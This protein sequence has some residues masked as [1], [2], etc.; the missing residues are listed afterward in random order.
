M[1]STGIVKTFGMVAVEA[2]V[3][4]AGLYLL[5][6]RLRGQATKTNENSTESKQTLPD[7]KP[8]EL[9]EDKNLRHRGVAT[10]T[11]QPEDVNDN[12][13]DERKKMNYYH[14][15]DDN[16]TT[17]RSL[18]TP[19][20]KDNSVQDYST[21][22]KSMPKYATQPLSASNMNSGVKR[23]SHEQ[24]G[25]SLQI[26]SEGKS[27]SDA[28]EIKKIEKLEKHKTCVEERMVGRTFDYVISDTNANIDDK[29]H[30]GTVTGNSGEKKF[31]FQISPTSKMQSPTCSTTID[32]SSS[33]V[34]MKK[35]PSEVTP[36]EIIDKIEK[37]RKRVHGLQGVDSSP[38]SSTV[39]TAKPTGAITALGPCVNEN[40]NSTKSKS[41]T[42]KVV[43]IRAPRLPDVNWD[44]SGPKSPPPQVAKHFESYSAPVALTDEQRLVAKVTGIEKDNLEND[45][46]D[47]TLEV[48]EDIVGDIETCKIKDEPGHLKQ[49]VADEKDVILKTDPSI[50]TGRKTPPEPEEETLKITQNVAV[51]RSFLED[52]PAGSFHILNQN[53]QNDSQ[54]DATNPLRFK[55]ND[56]YSSYHSD[57][58][59]LLINSQDKG[60]IP[61]R[62]PKYV[63]VKPVKYVKFAEENEIDTVNMAIDSGF[64]K[65]ENRAG[66]M[67]RG[68]LKSSLKR[69]ESDHEVEVGNLSIEDEA[70]ISPMKAADNENIIESTV[71][72]KTKDTQSF[73]KKFRS[74]SD[75][76]IQVTTTDEMDMLPQLP[77]SELNADTPEKENETLPEVDSDE[78]DNV[79]KHTDV[80]DADVEIDV[81]E[82]AAKLLGLGPDV[83]AM[84]VQTALVG[85]K[86]SDA[87]IDDF[88]I[89]PQNKQSDKKND[90]EKGSLIEEQVISA[91]VNAPFQK[92]DSMKMMSVPIVTETKCNT[93]SVNMPLNVRQ[94][95]MAPVKDPHQYS[96]VAPIAV[97]TENRLKSE[98]DKRR[99]AFFKDVIDAKPISSSESQSPWGHREWT[100][101]RVPKSSTT[102]MTEASNGVSQSAP[103]NNMKTQ[104][105]DTETNDTFH[106]T[107]YKKENTSKVY[108]KHAFEDISSYVISSLLGDL[109][110]GVDSEET[111]QEN[112]L[113][114]TSEDFSLQSLPERQFL[115]DIRN[116]VESEDAMMNENKTGSM[117]AIIHT[118]EDEA[119]HIGK[120]VVVQNDSRV[121]ES[122]ENE[123]LLMDEN[124]SKVFDQNESYVQNDVEDEDSVMNEHRNECVQAI[125]HTSEDNLQDINMITEREA[126]STMTENKILHALIHSEDNI[127]DVNKTMVVQSKSGTV[128]K[129]KNILVVQHENIDGKVI[130]EVKQDFINEQLSEDNPVNLY[131]DNT[132]P[133]NVTKT[134]PTPPIRKVFHPDWKINKSE[135][136]I[137]EQDISNTQIPAATEDETNDTDVLVPVIDDWISSP[138]VSIYTSETVDEMAE[139]TVLENK[140][141]YST[142]ENT[143][144][145]DSQLGSTST[146][147]SQPVQ[148]EQDP[149]AITRAMVKA[150]IQ[151]LEH[152]S[153]HATTEKFN[154]DSHKDATPK[155]QDAPKIETVTAKSSNPAPKLIIHPPK[156]DSSFKQRL[157]GFYDDNYEL[158]S[159]IS[160][161]S[162]DGNKVTKSIQANPALSAEAEDFEMLFE[163]IARWDTRESLEL[164]KRVELTAKRDGF[165]VLHQ[166]AVYNMPIIVTGL[167]VYGSYQ[168]IVDMLAGSE[169]GMFSGLSARDV[170][171]KC[172][173]VTVM[174]MI[175]KYRECE[176]Y[177]TSMHHAARGG[178]LAL[179][180]TLWENGSNINIAGNHGNTPLYMAVCAGQLRAVQ[181][182]LRYGGDP[183]IVCDREKTLLHKA[184]EWGHLHILKY[185]VSECGFDVNVRSKDG[186]TPLHLAASYGN[187]VIVKFLLDH[188]AFISIPSNFNETPLFWAI[189]NGNVEV[190]QMMVKRGARSELKPHSTLRA[191]NLNF[192]H[193]ASSSGHVE[194][195]M[196]LLDLGFNIHDVTFKS[197]E[198]NT[199]YAEGV[200]ALHLAAGHG[201]HNVVYFLVDQGAKVDARD[202]EDCTA[203]HYAA[204]Q[205]HPIT[206]QKLI[207]FNASINAQN[208]HL[209]TPLHKAALHGHLAVT[210]LLI[211]NGAYIDLPVLND[212]GGYTPLHLAAAE[213]HY[214]V[215]QLLVNQGA[216][217]D[218]I[219]SCKQTP[220]HLATKN[221]HLEIV[222]LLYSSGASL[223]MKDYKG[224]TPLSLAQKKKY[225]EISKFLKANGATGKSSLKKKLFKIGTPKS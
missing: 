168:E 78:C 175:D 204:E 156:T 217:L 118:S 57:P 17:I 116:K 182:L 221:G 23:N 70:D 133:R 35:K 90:S 122:F 20:N 186:I 46:Q 32:W 192:F 171:E 137:T 112:T 154:I 117:Q 50:T 15:K 143:T 59:K 82:R 29:R 48:M 160:A 95:E 67:S 104:N 207:H 41:V 163:S 123:D 162:I 111:S 213:A 43:T 177:L 150:A 220:L 187:P 28:Q 102:S 219:D 73:Y 159:N 124:K 69:V 147:I 167:Y 61:K 176:Y 52:R 2:V 189:A 97:V 191:R 149:D 166:A 179:I 106:E 205:G 38:L 76:D 135:P 24:Y 126:D 51:T 121:R 81:I 33:D 83:V 93:D 84:K 101:R 66:S 202:Q 14:E 201:H 75:D 132:F 173:N 142:K 74:L 152:T 199:Y 138:A 56:I 209:Y 39:Y 216:S 37:L 214:D 54:G 194:M 45:K 92:D 110:V 42:H 180:Q 224:E 107:A 80:Q 8:M 178:N 203:L 7:N 88:Y 89:T 114:E 174:Q 71:I 100:S 108:N 128:K 96:D 72:Q 113:S 127:P 68:I 25:S 210:E 13:D 125:V 12:T 6:R 155:I 185:L 165:T 200:T 65:D 139:P 60:A 145:P 16:E 26:K 47:C 99:D 49:S 4:V 64:M 183:I 103:G 151:K 105:F 63:S 225:S 181:L 211:D 130:E 36:Q 44:D 129:S 140:Q 144:I 31:S 119:W 197:M 131:A 10:K 9:Q 169:A 218:F 109:S 184:A 86:H 98:R 212:F 62:Y 11:H 22:S 19:T 115:D 141:L 34:P 153:T 158:E 164:M 136:V 198:M 206:I 18:F 161:G 193:V 222:Q 77:I 30:V 190:V 146:A 91:S 223:S 21:M 157:S 170:A 172:R 94:E 208:W 1:D 85:E 215:V 3:I 53:R 196:Y 40:I 27:I 148:Q 87:I 120:S 58:D 134:P 195:C 5:N 55:E 188:K 79:P